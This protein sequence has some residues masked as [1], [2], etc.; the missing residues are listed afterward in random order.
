MATST[1]SRLVPANTRDGVDTRTKDNCESAAAVNQ[2]TTCLEDG[3]QIRDEQTAARDAPH[4]HSRLWFERWRPEIYAFVSEIMNAVTED[5]MRHILA[6]APVKSGKREIVEC[7]ATWNSGRAQ[8]MYITSLNRVDIQTQQVEMKH[9]GIET[10]ITKDKPSCD[11]V[12]ASV[13]AW[14]TQLP[15][16]ILCCDE[17]DYGSGASQKMAGVF[18]AFLK[19]NNVVKLYF[20]ATSEETE[21]SS[22]AERDDYAFMVYTPPLTYRGAEYFIEEGLVFQPED[23]FFEME[24]DG[25]LYVTDHGK[26]VCRDSMTDQ[27]HIGC[28]RASGKISIFKNPLVKK[29]IERQLTE[30]MPNGRVWD[31]RVIDMSAPMGWDVEETRD[32]FI[33]NKRKNYLFILF[34]TCTRGTDLK[35]WHHKLA[36]WHDA[37]SCKNSNLNTLVQ[38]MLRPCH[39]AGSFEGY[40]PEGERIRMYVD[41]NVMDMAAYDNL[42]VYLEASGKPPARTK[43]TGNGPT[44]EYTIH[45]KATFEELAPI[46]EAI[47]QVPETLDSFP[48]VNG[49]YCPT[50]FGISTAQRLRTVWSRA[51]AEKCLKAQY[52]RV[53]HFKYV[54]C[55]R[56]TTDPSSLTWFIVRK[57]G[58]QKNK[59]RMPIAATKSSMFT[60][61]K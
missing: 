59:K 16:S 15:M 54:P 6:K 17:C 20:S 1:V 30:S 12:I 3:D 4:P 61:T 33:N 56:D 2:E 38:A 11:N 37:R 48:L 32:G 22:L 41:V 24:S 53:Q 47:G 44:Y 43:R 39:Y 13:K 50:S 60:V 14:K 35:G 49:F 55:Y 5:G 42:D 27:R 26:N 34:Q 36:F 57:L 52:N 46:V 18:N 21:A 28:V 23:N 51:D 29:D 25:M 31:V 45:E 19:D 9:Y 7:I 40:S 10:Y 8:V 58:P